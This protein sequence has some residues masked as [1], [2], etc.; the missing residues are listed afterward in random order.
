MPTAT[1]PD[2][3]CQECAQEVPAD[4]LLTLLEGDRWCP[5]CVG[6]DLVCERCATATRHTSLTMQDGRLCSDCTSGYERCDDCDS[7]ADSTY[8]VDGGTEVCGG[9]ACASIT[10]VL[11]EETVASI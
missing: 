4:H 5:D 7:L 8:D 1:V 11:A 10:G 2:A 6:E 9:F 3:R